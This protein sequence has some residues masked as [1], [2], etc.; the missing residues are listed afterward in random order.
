MQFHYTKNQLY[1]YI[2]YNLSQTH[3]LYPT[4]NRTRF[5]IQTFDRTAIWN[6]KT[7][8]TEP[9]DSAPFTIAD[10]EHTYTFPLALSTDKG[11]ILSFSHGSGTY[12]IKV[13]SMGGNPPTEIRL[14]RV[15]YYLLAGVS[16]RRL[17]CQIHSRRSM[18]ALD[19]TGLCADLLFIPNFHILCFRGGRAII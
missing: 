12:L 4:D 16:A 17:E 7:M 19:L 15:F 14:L 9:Q 13:P 18:I 1:F 6:W 10:S 3:T 8:I 11:G 2:F 5:P